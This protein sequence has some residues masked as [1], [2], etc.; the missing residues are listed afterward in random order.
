M[1]YPPIGT[2]IPPAYFQ[3]DMPPCS[4]GNEDAVM[5]SNNA[6]IAGLMHTH[7]NID[8]NGNYPVKAPSP[9]DIKYLLNTLLSQ[10]NQY[11]GSYSNAY[12]ITITSEGSYMLMYTGTAYP[13]SLDYDAVK[14]LKEDYTRQFQKF[15]EENSNMS[16]T[17]VERIFTKFMK[18][19][20]NK[21]GLEAYR[22]TPTSAVKIEYDPTSPNSVKETPCP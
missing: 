11:T 16:Q 22:I 5:P 9:V 6:G 13:G 17:D 7:N 18:E 10:A 14:K 19:K 1:R 15:Y 8:C 20:I 21:P 4:T 3:V 2:N 12:S